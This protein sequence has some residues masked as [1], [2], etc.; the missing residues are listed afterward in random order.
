MS[1]SCFFYALEVSILGGTQS[2]SAAGDK[3]RGWG[4]HTLRRVHKIRSPLAPSL[5]IF[6]IRKSVL[7]YFI[8]PRFPGLPH[9]TVLTVIQGES[10]TDLL[11]LPERHALLSPK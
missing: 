8:I 10:H 6:D 2:S 1:L 7:L 5:S 11:L 9:F 3:R 4:R